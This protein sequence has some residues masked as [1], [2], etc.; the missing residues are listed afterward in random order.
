MSKKKQT[1]SVTKY[2][3]D[4]GAGYEVEG[5]AYTFVGWLWSF[6]V[7]AEGISCSPPVF[8]PV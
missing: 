6:S 5:K 7:I 1:R 8:S 3:E 4:S 2:L